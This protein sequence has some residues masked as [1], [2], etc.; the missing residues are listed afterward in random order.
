MALIWRTTFLPF[1][2]RIR[3]MTSDEAMSNALPNWSKGSST[4]GKDDWS[5]LS[6]SRSTT[7]RSE[8]MLSPVQAPPELIRE[9]VSTYPHPGQT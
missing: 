1:S 7:S 5:E 9:K 8:A 3:L 4:S 2:T 6:S